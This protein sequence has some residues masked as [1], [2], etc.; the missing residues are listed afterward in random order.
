M[1]PKVSP[2]GHVGW[3]QCSG[4]DQ[5][6][7]AMNQKLIIHLRNGVTKQFKANPDAPFIEAWT[8][9]D[10]DSEVLIQS[11]GFH[12]PASY[13]R[14]DLATGRKTNEKA[15]RDDSEALPKWLGRLW[16]RTVFAN[17]CLQTGD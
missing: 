7:Y 15:G 12:G 8:F 16:I 10:N 9:V 6:G 5:K 2:T 17:Q 3:T 4:F 1:E 13:I 14:Y 11:R